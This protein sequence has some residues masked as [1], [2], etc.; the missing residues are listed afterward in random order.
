MRDSSRLPDDSEQGFSCLFT[1]L[2][3]GDANVR[4]RYY[5]VCQLWFA[6]DS[7]KFMDNKVARGKHCRDDPE[8]VSRA[9]HM[10]QL[11]RKGL[12]RA[13][14]KAT[15]RA[16]NSWENSSDRYRSEDTSRWSD[17]TSNTAEREHTDRLQPRARTAQRA[18]DRQGQRLLSRCRLHWSQ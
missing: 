18:A 5:G 6:S 12:S 7:G 9:S 16:D 8:H 13:K 2:V 11:R 15:G 14:T 17:A 10:D 4:A 3:V 1:G